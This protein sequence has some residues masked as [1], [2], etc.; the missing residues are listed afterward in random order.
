M[1]VPAVER[2]GSDARV[3]DVRA[4]NRFYTAVIG[5]LDEGLATSPYSLTEARVLFELAHRDATEVS[6]LRRDL[7]VDAGYLS[8]ILARFTAD[9]LV[10]RARSAVDRRRQLVG[11]TVAG[12]A[13]FARVDALSTAQVG[14]LLGRLPGAEQ[15]RLLA[16]MDTV[17]TLLLPAT[18][19][20]PISPVGAGAV[21]LR[22]PAPGELG[23][24]VQRNGALYAQEYG[25]NGS[26]EALVARI[27]AD[28]AQNRD[29]ARE[30]A[31]I[32]ETDG[33]PVGCVFC[34]R[35]DDDTAKLR[36]LLVEPS[37]RGRGVGGR[38]VDECLDFA[39]RA[40]YRRMVLWTNDVLTAARRIYVRAGF[41][42]AE[43]EPHTSFGADLVGEN[44]TRDL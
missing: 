15:D 31:W 28:Y 18:A 41:T 25:W 5:V 42:L 19:A 43:R 6:A 13:A 30:A 24:V 44:W 38:L 22:P 35:L 3:A 32:A 14:G 21:L 37:A 40:G 8:R 23:W 34:V 9:G 7:G 36:L 27:V 12:R 11:L 20:G 10:E 33:R 16:A 17:R 29:P 39:R 1:V 4:F 2:G 26:Y